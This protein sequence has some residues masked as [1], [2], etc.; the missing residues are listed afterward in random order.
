[1]RGARPPSHITEV[2]QAMMRTALVILTLL[3][4]VGLLLVGL[5]GCVSPAD[6]AI[7]ASSPT[8]V[9]PTPTLCPLATPEPLWVDLVTSP[10][11]QLTQTIT[12]YLGNGE[13]VTVT[14]ESLLF[15]KP[16]YRDICSPSMTVL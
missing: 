5:N 8:P 1:M 7:A 4:P 10:T 16:V 6:T 9:T 12:V 2:M 14:A 13:A 15:S 3:I 11:D